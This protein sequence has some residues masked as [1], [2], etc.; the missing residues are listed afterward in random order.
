MD[1][2]GEGS[3]FRQ[4]LRVSLR[5]CTR[6]CDPSLRGHQRIRGT[7]SRLRHGAIEPLGAGGRRVIAERVRTG[8]QDQ[9]G[10]RRPT[11]RIC[12]QRVV[13]PVT[14]ADRPN[15]RE[16]RINIDTQQGE[17]GRRTGHA[18]GRAAEDDGVEPGQFG[19]EVVQ[20]EGWSIGSGDFFSIQLPL[21]GGCARCRNRQRGVSSDCRRHAGRLRRDRR[22]RLVPGSD[23]N[24]LT[25]KLAG[26]D[27]EPLGR[28]SGHLLD[29]LGAFC[30]QGSA[31]GSPWPQSHT[32]I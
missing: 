24:G 14:R 8:G 30:R 3:V 22:R 23:H 19:R 4:A 26:S 13:D 18:A 21:V 2:D 12:L 28:A 20:R 1:A 25:E 17:R 31:T 7:N 10:E 15:D 27:D 16:G 9:S 11:R 29:R 32:T 6:Q 5:A